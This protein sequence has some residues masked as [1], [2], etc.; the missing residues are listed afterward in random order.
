MWKHL[1]AW[2]LPTTDARATKTASTRWPNAGNTANW[3][4]SLES[5]HGRQSLTKYAADFA[6]CAGMRLPATDAQGHTI[7]C[8]SMDPSAKTAGQEQCP[9]GYRCTMLAFMGWAWKAGIKLC[10]L[11]KI[12]ESAANQSFKVKKKSFVAHEFENRPFLKR[13]QN[14]T[15]CAHPDKLFPINLQTCMNATTVHNAKKGRNRHKCRRVVCRQRWLAK[16]ATTNSARQ[17]LTA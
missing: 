14:A 10:L 8:A 5:S 3:V 9:S 2:H 4:C 12:S 16:P 6:G 11:H 13:R 1:N 7:I 17:A 15:N